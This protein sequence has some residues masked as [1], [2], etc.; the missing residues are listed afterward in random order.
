[1]PRVVKRE[2]YFYIK[3]ADRRPI[4]PQTIKS[5]ILFFLES[6]SKEGFMNL[7]AFLSYTQTKLQ[8]PAN[9]KLVYAKYVRKE[10]KYKKIP[11]TFVK[12]PRIWHSMALINLTKSTL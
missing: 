3:K 12:G 4:I 6:G 9:G 11:A 7:N 8:I 10:L 5:G 1:M 2:S